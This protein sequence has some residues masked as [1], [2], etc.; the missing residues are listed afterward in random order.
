MIF[1]FYKINFKKRK[2][3]EQ[4]EKYD[5][6]TEEWYQAVGPSKTSRWHIAR[7]G[8]RINETTLN[9]WVREGGEKY[10]YPR[11]TLATSICR[12][13]KR[14]RRTSYEKFYFRHINKARQE[15]AQEIARNR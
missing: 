1:S 8:N 5:P 15:I 9:A 11:L 2:M 3:A 13:T 14:I 7:L 12:H 10:E 4:F 6:W